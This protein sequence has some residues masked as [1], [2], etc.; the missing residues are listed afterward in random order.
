MYNFENWRT[1]L[2]LSYQHRTQH[3]FPA[4]FH[5]D[6]SSFN[7]YPSQQIESN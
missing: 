2:K 6:P 4:P 3:L 7:F 1:R 5:L